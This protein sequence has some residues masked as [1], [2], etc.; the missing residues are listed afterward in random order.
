M[1][2]KS[3]QTV[4][5]DVTNQ[6]NLRCIFCQR[7]KFAPHFMSPETFRQI[8]EK[9]SPFIK[10]FLLSCA[11]EYT[12][13]PKPQ[14]ILRILGQF[15]F[16][17]KTIFTNGNILTDEMIYA[18]IEAN[19]RKYVFSI[20]ESTPETYSYV[21]KGGRL[22]R[23]MSNMK[24]MDETKERMGKGPIIAVNMT[25]LRS[26]IEELPDFVSKA[27]GLGVQS[28]SGRHLILNKGLGMQEELVT[29]FGRANLLIESAQSIA[30]RAGVS[31][32]VPRYN[33]HDPQGKN[34]TA[35]F[36]QWHVASNGDV[37]ICPRIHKYVTIG[38]I[39]Q[40]SFDS[41]RNSE[42]VRNLEAEF[43]N[44]SFTNPVCDLCLDGKENEI[45]IDQGF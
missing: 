29:D 2:D 11:W 44:R 38:N 17:Y 34:C 28:I 27:V 20:N 10:H 25:L 21:R 45:E 23:V 31:F 4:L 16:D 33:S 5:F 32:Q 6:C 8:L 42:A 30:D 22:D 19:V 18:V 43:K 1:S 40:Q 14:E 39:A 7:Q 26:N 41:I 13:H 35:V 3:V 9:I 37:S 24:R 12:T 15:D 36:N